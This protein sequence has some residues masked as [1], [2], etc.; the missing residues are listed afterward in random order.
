VFIVLSYNWVFLDGYLT[1][2]R[3]INLGVNLN[4]NLVLIVYYCTWVSLGGYL[5]ITRLLINLGANLN[6][7]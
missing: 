2:K 5:T 3:L 6:K 4:N 7:S 1:I